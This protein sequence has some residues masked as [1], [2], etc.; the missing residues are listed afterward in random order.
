M[1]AGKYADGNVVGEPDALAAG[2]GHA[3]RLGHLFVPHQADALVRAD[4]CG[5]RVARDSFRAPEVVEVR[6]ADH[7]EVGAVDL[8]GRHAYGRRAGCPIDERVE[9]EDKVIDFETEGR[10]AKPI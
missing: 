9:E 8:R 3:L 4:Y 5:P 7:D 2:D 6:V 1:L 10:A